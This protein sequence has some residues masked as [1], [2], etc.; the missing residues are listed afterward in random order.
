MLS[1]AVKRIFDFTCAAIGVCL[2]GWLMI[3]CWCLARLD[4]KADGFFIQSRVGRNGQTFPLLKF[5]SMRHVAGVTT[6]VT[7]ANDSRITKFGSLLRATKLDE[8]PQLLNVLCGHMSLVGPRP[9]V[10]GWADELSGED[11][12]ILDMRPGVTGPASLHFRNEEQL[13]AE[14]V[15]AESYNRDKI[16]PEKVS[17]NRRYYYQQSFVADL[18][19]LIKTAFPSRER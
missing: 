5:R 2:L 8:L 15:D 12:V 7:A 16:W 17:I 9:D 6:T 14:A 10:P 18:K 19:I 13:L 11:A 1:R 4:T 3:I